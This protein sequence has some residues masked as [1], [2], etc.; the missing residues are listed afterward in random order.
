MRRVVRLGLSADVVRYLKR[1]QQRADDEQAAGTLEVDKAWKSACQTLKIKSV[2]ATL[3]QMAGGRQRCMYC[4]DS[5]GTDI[6]HS[7]PKSVYTERMFQ[8]LN[9]LLCCTGCGRDCKGTKFPLDKGNPVLLDP[10]TDD[11]W[12]FLDFS[13]TTGILF[14]LADIDGRTTTKGKKTVELLKLDQR[15]E[16]N[17][18]YQKSF[19]RIKRAIDAAVAER[20]PDATVLIHALTDADDHGLLGWCFRG[21][22]MNESPLSELRQT[23]LAVW[24][25]CE[26]AFRNL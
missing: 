6:E 24:A 21:N 22:G 25:A 12:Q 9:M 10:T 18:G 4:S 20:A 1:R 3:K 14:P 17:I 23:H 26:Q 19:R 7:W 8:W 11:P 15:D 16:V 5:A 2:R 13:T